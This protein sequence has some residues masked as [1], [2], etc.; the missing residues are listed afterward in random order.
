MSKDSKPALGKQGHALSPVAAPIDRT[1]SLGYIRQADL[2]GEPHVTQE[3]AEANRQAGRTPVRA[4][5]GRPG[6]V[7]FSSATL[8]RKVKS[9]DFPAPVKLSDR[10]TAWKIQ[11]VHAW[12]NSFTA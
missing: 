3:E 4:R 7:P 10:V 11:D 9:G 2:I 1:S 12:L 5:I 8:W 6:M